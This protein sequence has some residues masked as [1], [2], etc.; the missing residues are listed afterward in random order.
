MNKFNRNPRT[1]TLRRSDS[2]DGVGMS[3]SADSDT[4]TNHIIRDVEEGSPAARA[5]LRKN[6]RLISVNGVNV[7]NIDFGDVL[8]LVREGLSNDN[9][10]VSVIHEI[11]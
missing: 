9:L 5:G 8:I 2:Y 4:R 11:D 10:Q 1:Y 3:I 6:D 7:E